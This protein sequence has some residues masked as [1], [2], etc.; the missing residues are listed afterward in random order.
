MEI[1]K[2]D[3]L[4]TKEC[5]P[6]CSLKWEPFFLLSKR[7]GWF[8]RK[9]I[10]TW[11]VER[12]SSGLWFLP[13]SKWVSVAPGGFFCVHPWLSFFILA[14][15]YSTVICWE[16][17]A[18]ATVLWGW[19]EINLIECLPKARHTE[20]LGSRLF[21]Q[22]YCQVPDASLDPE[23]NKIDLCPPRSSQ[24]PRG[25]PHPGSKQASWDVMGV[26]PCRS[27]LGLLQGPSF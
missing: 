11:M 5:W 8:I 3:P 1:I 21:C 23:I 10:F 25:Q 7:R 15:I 19:D 20:V 16:I 13:R 22:Q 26:V 17:S 14:L 24:P 6:I 18:A 27:L 4:S 12:V 9:P 2:L